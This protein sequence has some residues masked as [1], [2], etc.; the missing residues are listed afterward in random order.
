MDEIH[1]MVA[2]ILSGMSFREKSVIAK[3]DE[4]ALPYLQYAFDRYISA[5]D[6][7]DEGA[8]ADIM[9]RMWEACRET[10]RLRSVK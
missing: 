9:R 4:E 8:G 5:K 2:D 7:D 1:E 3:M 10:H 6:P